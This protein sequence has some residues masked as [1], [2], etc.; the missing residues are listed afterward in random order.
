[1]RFPTLR[2]QSLRTQLVVTLLLLAIA[3]LFATGFYAY[4]HAR[5][6]LTEESGEAMESIAHDTIDKVDR[7]LFER[8]GDVQAFAFHPGARGTSEE[9][10]AAMNFFTRC[11]GLYDLML[12]ADL[13]GRIVACNSIDAKGAAI[14]SRGLIG[15]SVAGEPWFE[16]IRSGKTK[17][18]ETW[19]ADPIQDPLCSEAYGKPVVT[20][21]FSAPITDEKGNVVRVWS[22][23][24]S[25]ERTVGE[26]LHGVHEDIEEK[27]GEPV[28]LQLCSKAGLLLDTTH[29]SGAFE[30]NLA[31]AG[32]ES[33]ILG[34]QGKDGFVLHEG[35]DGLREYHGYAA[36]RGALGF[37]GYGWT[38]I[39]RESEDDT[40]DG[41]WTLRS[42]ILVG[43]A[44][45]ALVLAFLG[46][47]VALS[48]ARPV[49]KTAEVLEA[50]AHGDLQ[51]KLEVDRADELG[52]MAG[53]LNSTGDVLRSLVAETSALTAA[54]SEGRLSTRADA[55]RFEGGYRALCTGMNSMLD[56][57]L[58]PVDESAKVMRALA[59]GD[60]SQ[61]V[62]GDYRGDHRVLQESLN[63]TIVVLRTL[64]ADMNRLIEASE[65]GRLSERAD[66]QRF[67]GS[68][69]ELVAQVNRMLD[70]VVAPMNEA[71]DVLVAVSHGDLSRSVQGDYRGDHETVKRHLN[72]TIGV[73][74]ELVQELGRIASACEEGR[75]ETRAKPERFSGE[76][77]EVCLRVNRMIDGI[78]APIGEATEVLG[79]VAR[80]D[81]ARGVTGA[82]RGD[83]ER[84]KQGL[85]TTLD[86]LRRLLHETQGLITACQRGELST[87]LDAGQFD[88]SYSELC[89]SINAM[90]DVV[91]RP[92]DE[93]TRVLERMAAQ[94]L[95]ARIEGRYEGDHAKMQIAVN[96]A[97]ERM[98]AAIASIGSDARSL[99]ASAAELTKASQAIGEQ[100]GKTAE[101]VRSVSSSTG[102]IDANVQTVA[103]AAE[104]MN[105]SIREIAQR[106]SEA[107]Q[108][109]GSA[110]EAVQV[111]SAA[112]GRL[113]ESSAEIESVIKLITSIAAQTNLLALNATIEAARAG[114]MGK[115]FAVVANEVKDLANQTSK[116]TEEIAGKIR[117]IQGDTRTAVDSMQAVQKVI[118][119]ISGLQSSIAGAVE[120]QSATTQ[121]IARNVT[122]VARKT[123]EIAQTMS[124]VAHSAGETSAGGERSGRAALEVEERAS[125]LRALVARFSIA[126]AQECGGG[127]TG[128]SRIEPSGTERERQPARNA[129]PRSLIGV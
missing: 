63:G 96:T 37:P 19:Y 36:S 20:L 42:E 2:F 39:V 29:G 103:S 31:Q 86:V 35:A 62:R 118:D 57:V 76:Y 15:R 106:S 70:A 69:R 30:T 38:L 82:Y 60:L 94:D 28:N 21:N 122:E 99:S 6:E 59:Q 43:I 124:S 52:R 101:Q 12:V 88:G 72:E 64:V 55:S 40:L 7:L 17:P 54:A 128:P 61:E 56:A 74:R 68:Y 115:G 49:T 58:Q 93:S 73:L 121:E 81:L 129:S 67:E 5:Q 16:A 84:I 111:T 89:T 18:G 26:L 123:S 109:V 71:R 4:Y 33:A 100:A 66:P 51:Q 116:A 83:H 23:R 105:A 119:R 41:V 102:E 95:T 11:Y 10:E 27:S 46:W 90:L 104:E 120:E 97:A 110:V 25:W 48:V 14:A 24:A 53:A 91:V 98:G 125:G 50:L 22:N 117:T 77:A 92:I 85:N 75:L 78:L 127:E 34:A 44:I 80:G 13:D 1:M 108:C 3:P 126:S 9:T 65:A 87:R 79:N 47:R 8:Y 32:F 45:T 107:S 113:G 114:E 112:V